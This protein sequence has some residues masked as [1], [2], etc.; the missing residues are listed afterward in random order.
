LAHGAGD[1]GRH[2]PVPSQT[3]AGVSVEPLQ[4]AAAHVVLPPGF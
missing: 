1:A 3:A 2:A 4:L